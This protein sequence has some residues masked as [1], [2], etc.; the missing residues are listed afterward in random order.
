MMNLYYNP[1]EFGLTQVAEIDYSDR[2]YVFDR[3]VVWQHESGAF[4]TARDSG[5]S[6]PSPFE[7]YHGVKELDR[8][9]FAVLEREA[10]ARGC[11]EDWQH[12]HVSLEEC[13]AFLDT[14]RKAIG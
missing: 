2:Y 7:D 6:C 11:V 9:D 8:L 10:R 4:Y 14:V 5:C 12:A 3:R 1:E 13:E